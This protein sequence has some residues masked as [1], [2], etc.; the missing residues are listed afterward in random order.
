VNDLEDRLR[1]DLKT[2]A[3]RAKPGAVRPLRTPAPSRRSRTRRW[4]APV[5]A[6][7][8]VA[9]VISAVTL[10]G[11]SVD[12]RPAQAG[13][14]PGMPP[15]YVALHEL[16]SQGKRVVI[17]VTVRSSASG[18]VLTSKVIPTPDLY[19]PSKPLLSGT[20]TSITAAA[21]DLTF[22][23]SDQ[24]GVYVLHL[25]ANGRSATLTTVPIKAKPFYLGDYGAVISPDGRQLAIQTA[26]CPRHA[27]CTSGQ[28]G[29]E[30]VSL[31]SAAVTKVWLAPVRYGWFEGGAQWTDYGRE[32]LF[33]WYP[34]S[35]PGGAP[36]SELRALSATSRG[37]SLLADSQLIRSEPQGRTSSLFGLLTPDGRGL[38]STEYHS[39]GT[40]NHLTTTARLVEFSVRTG[41]VL[42]VLRTVTHVTAVADYGLCTPMSAGPAELNVL[43]QCIGFG[44]LEGSHF[45]P[46]PGVPSALAVAGVLSPKVTLSRQLA[47]CDTVAW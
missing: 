1:R 33:R 11:N 46:L 8:A 40:A 41:R 44:R 34:D 15:Y 20:Q 5:A 6:M 25:A 12:H 27:L 43:V 26:T 37:S 17:D 39:A 32:L 16:I 13:A 9:A 36:P 19:D 45:T 22:A 29:L 14:P 3:H 7:A 2:L 23:I 28:E 30:I 38:I 31:P 4:L 18:A 10:A 47:A 42:R 35:A 24:Y 21:D